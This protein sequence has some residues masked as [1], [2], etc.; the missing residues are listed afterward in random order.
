M[1]IYGIQ[2]KTHTIVALGLELSSH[3]FQQLTQQIFEIN[4]ANT[5]QQ[6]TNGLLQILHITLTQGTSQNGNNALA[7]IQAFY[8][9]EA[10]QERG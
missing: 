10:C 4:T 9:P 1:V 7:Q 5:V 8:L 6:Q 3:L 2:Y